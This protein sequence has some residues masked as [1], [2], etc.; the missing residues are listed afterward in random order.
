MA[1]RYL[2]LARAHMPK[3]RLIYSVADLHHLRLARQA[4]VEQ[5]P[6]WLALARATERNE[7]LAASQADLVLTHSPAEARILHKHFP[8]KVSVVP[9]A[10]GEHA[11]PPSFAER[12]G[13]A[14][15]G[16]FDH[17]PNADAAYWLVNEIL[18]R[19]WATAPTL[20]CK[21]VGHGWRASSLGALDPRVE[22][23]GPIENLDDLFASVRLTIA[24]LR[25]GAGVKGKVLESFAAAVPCVMT[26]VA[27]EGMP[28]VA[29]LPD[30]VGRDAA[31][32]AAL[33]L[34]F[35]DD[36][37]V[38]V[39]CGSQARALVAQHFSQD[40]VI[41]GLRVALAAPADAPQAL[42]LSA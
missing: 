27:A 13:V 11:E 7:W 3:A 40:R 5:R 32:I 35:H 9:F 37:D 42:R 25:F 22:I 16:S 29:P 31:D 39:A 8:M 23:V 30:L 14:F 38:N 24:P 10:V 2:N 6:E 26:E 21:I 28:L 15:L 12:H 19:V 41:D 4:M 1:E 34:R 33:I 18:P 36:A 17:S 20:T